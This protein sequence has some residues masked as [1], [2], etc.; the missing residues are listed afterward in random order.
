LYWKLNWAAAIRKGDWKL[1]RTPDDQH[2]LFNLA[3][4]PSENENQFK[5]KPKIAEELLADLKTW[6]AQLMTPIWT[7]SQKWKKHSLQRYN[8][9]TVNGFQKN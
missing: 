5:A 1:V 4:D 8:Q 7:T 9:K 3:K 2:W 6:E